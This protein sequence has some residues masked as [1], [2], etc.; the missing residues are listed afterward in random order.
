[1]QCMAALV[2]LYS[3]FSAVV[4]SNWNYFCKFVHL[5]LARRINSTARIF[6]GHQ[7]YWY[8]D[9]WDNWNIHKIFGQCASLCLRFSGPSDLRSEDRCFHCLQKQWKYLLLL[10][11]K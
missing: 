5:W 3:E 11:S 10:I 7:W 4:L 6:T 2:F 1:M 8:N 9:I